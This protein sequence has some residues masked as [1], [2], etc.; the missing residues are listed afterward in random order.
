MADDAK[1]RNVLA[2]I[3]Y[4]GRWW[5]VTGALLVAFTLWT[6][7]FHQAQTTAILASTLRHSTPLVLGALCGMLGERSG[8][9]RKSV[10]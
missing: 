4:R 3:L 8:V 9:D 10:V 6:A 2:A 7:E 1:G 5:L